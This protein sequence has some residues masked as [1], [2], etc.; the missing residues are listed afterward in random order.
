MISKTSQNCPPLARG[1]RRRR[2]VGVVPL[3]SPAPAHAP[4]PPSNP[5]PIP[6]RVAP[7][8]AAP[9]LL[10]SSPQLELEQR[11]LH[12]LQR[13]GMGGVEWRCGVRGGVGARG[14]ARAAPGVVR[15]C[16]GAGRARCA[17]LRCVGG[18]W[19]A[20]SWAAAGEGACRQRASCRGSRGAKAPRVWRAPNATGRGGVALCCRA[21]LGHPATVYMAGAR[22]RG[23]PPTCDHHARH[24][25][26]YLP[27]AEGGW[28]WQGGCGLRR[29]SRGCGIDVRGWRG[30]CV[31]EAGCERS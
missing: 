17:Q 4:Q 1:A 31:R 8:P 12:T 29:A 30:D 20:G 6:L 10:P 24:E 5:P 16:Y 15:G 2:R 3:P 25:A 18:S 14:R 28:E 7:S 27:G 26:R 9:S 11:V 23:R 19:A 22:G 21:R 13:A